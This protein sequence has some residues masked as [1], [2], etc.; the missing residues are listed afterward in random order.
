MGQGRIHKNT[1]T[2]CQNQF[3]WTGI[4]IILTTLKYF[5]NIFR[6]MVR[7]DTYIPKRRR[8][9]NERDIFGSGDAYRC[10]DNCSAERPSWHEMTDALRLTNP[11]KYVIINR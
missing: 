11:K 3:P 7:Y 6:T 2:F 8:N 10:A 9:R 4:F 5:T 1:V